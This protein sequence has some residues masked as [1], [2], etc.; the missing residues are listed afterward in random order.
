MYIATKGRAC[1]RDVERY[2]CR[3]Q[4]RLTLIVGKRLFYCKELDIQRTAELDFCPL[5]VIP[6]FLSLQ[7]Q[8]GLSFP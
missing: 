1:C 6:I 5:Y 8:P 3:V 2:N 7:N 4:C